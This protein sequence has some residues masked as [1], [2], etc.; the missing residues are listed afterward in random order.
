MMDSRST[1]PEGFDRAVAGDGLRTVYQP[2][3][4][5]PEGCTV[6][7][8]ALARWTHVPTAL[9]EAVFRHAARSGQALRLERNCIEAAITGAR[10]AGL[11]PGSALFINCEAAA[12]FVSRS[13]SSVLDYGAD[14]YQIVFE[15]T[16][17]DLLADPANLLRK[18]VAL[19]DE[20]FAV[21]LDD[22]GSAAESLALLDVLAPDVIKLDLTV[23]QSQPRYRQARTWAA[24]LEHHE[25][26]G[27][28]VVAEGIETEEHFDRALALGAT[29]GQGFR[30]GHPEPL[31]E[32]AATS[33]PWPPIR[34]QDSCADFGSP[35]EAMLNYQIARVEPRPMAVRRYPRSTV[36]ALSVSL[37]QQAL[38]ASDPPMVLS[39][40][41]NAMSFT[42]D[43]RARLG[44]L[45]ERSPLVAVFGVDVAQNLDFGIRGVC[46]DHDD[47][48]RGQ[49]IVVALGANIAAT[50]VC[51]EVPSEDPANHDGSQFFDVA[52]SNDRALVTRIA[53]QLL[54][55]MLAAR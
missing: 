48:L 45:A 30:F 29:M 11:T 6:G 36:I 22:V 35:F 20:G 26:A 37:A 27:A 3:V 8:E 51:R 2:I 24:V 14:T 44:H 5:L 42:G 7:F 1:S 49:F 38:E 47:S 53:R 4:S 41:Q 12:P 50:V 43:T 18:V 28:H 23:V 32:D 25:R 21:A 34:T 13:H 52:A 15:V 46:F 9:C 31:S 54:S 39:A 19:R 17:R 55:R 16:E 33:S 10:D 40:L